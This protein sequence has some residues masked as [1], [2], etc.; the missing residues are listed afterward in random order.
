LSF[1]QRVEV[2][3]LNVFDERHGGGGLIGHIAHQNR[4]RL[5]ARQARSAKT[6]LACNDL[7][8][9]SVRAFRKL[10]HQNWLHDAL[11]L[12]RLG[13]FVQGTFVHA[14]ARL[15]HAGH[16]LLK[17]ELA[18]LTAVGHR[19]RVLNFGAQQ[20]FKPAAQSFGFFG[21][22]DHSFMRVCKSAWP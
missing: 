6:A 21:D 13:Q 22:H 12:D 10:T 7:V 4:D 14:G 16:H 1:F 5:E 2:F 19:R 15:V 3:A 9:A 8:L 18:G 11:R 20:G 17:L